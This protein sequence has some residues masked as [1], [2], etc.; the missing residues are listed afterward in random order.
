MSASTYQH[1]QT[2][3]S[4][5]GIIKYSPMKPLLKTALVN[6]L[7]TALY[8]TAVASFMFFAGEAKLGRNNTFLIPIVMLLLFVSSAAITGFLIFG[9]PVLL[10]LDGKKKD[11]LTLLSYT[12]GLLSIITLLAITYLV[13]F[14]T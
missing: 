14:G 1:N 10:Y 5:R 13:A 8:I 4:L 12:L 2:A 9:R 3:K 11:S 7:A 6:V